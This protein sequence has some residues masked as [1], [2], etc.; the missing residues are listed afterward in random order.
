ML[1]VAVDPMITSVGRDSDDISE[2]VLELGPSALDEPLIMIGDGQLVLVIE[3]TF[4]PSVVKVRAA[5][6]EG[7][8]RLWSHVVVSRSN[9]L[10]GWFLQ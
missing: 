5:D 9:G 6:P 4:E 2:L 8:T 10:N 3:S 7:I 1:I